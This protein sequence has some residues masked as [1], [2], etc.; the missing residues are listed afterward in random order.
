MSL[1][2]YCNFKSG[3]INRKIMVIFLKKRFGASYRMRAV[4]ALLYGLVNF[5]APLNHTCY[6][7]KEY[8]HG[9]N[10]E[11]SNCHFSEESCAGTHLGIE[12]NKNGSKNKVLSDRGRCPACLF[13]LIS[14]LYKLNQA[15]LQILGEDVV[16]VQFVYPLNFTKQFEWLSSAP[17]R[18]PPLSPPKVVA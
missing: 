16:K 13:S 2:L 15:T 4:I 5:A 9:C 6:S 1:Y 10:L 3:V 12:L 11:E 17:L 14:K 18:A 8:P 7:M